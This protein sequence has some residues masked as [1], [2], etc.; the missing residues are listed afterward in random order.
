MI[1]YFVQTRLSKRRNYAVYFFEPSEDEAY[2][3]KFNALYHSQGQDDGH[4]G[5]METATILDMR[6]EL[7]QM[8]R[9]KDESGKARKRLNLSNLYTAIWWYADFPNHYAGDGSKATRA[10]GQL[11]DEHYVSQL[12]QAL[13]TVKADQ[14]T[15]KL[16]N[17]FFDRLEKLNK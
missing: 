16:Q 4:A 10:L 1:R 6:P 11:I 14:E 9:A 7:V 5:E 8:D 13:N 17:E 2:K 15:L 3:K 12:A